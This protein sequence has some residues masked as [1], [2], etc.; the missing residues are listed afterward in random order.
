[1]LSLAILEPVGGKHGKVIGL[2]L[3][4]VLCFGCAKAQGGEWKEVGKITL[5]LVI[6]SFS[7]K[8]PRQT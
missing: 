5:N 6:S 4:I 1:M 2:A 7:M 8:Q 3:L